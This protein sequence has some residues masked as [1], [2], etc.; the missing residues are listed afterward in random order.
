MSGRSVCALAAVL[1][2]G[3]YTLEPVT[4]PTPVVGSEVAFDITDAGRVALGGSM[5]PE[6]E[7]IEGRLVER[8]SSEYVVA[9]S[10]VHLLRGGEQTW[11]GEPVHI[12]SQYV[13]TMY[14]KRFS[15]SRSVVL[16]AIG[17]GIAA[18]IATQQLIGGG[19][20]DPATMPSDTGHTTRR[21]P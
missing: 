12:K 5:G 7:Q 17:V 14:E 2:T 3:C 19:S 21:R 1:L 6:I 9:V 20:Q 13:G 18:A 11:S 4:G 8:D 10:A 15:K 16:G